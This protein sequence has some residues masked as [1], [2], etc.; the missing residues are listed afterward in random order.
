M[1]FAADGRLAT[2]SFDGK[3]R[4]YGADLAGNVHPSIKVD[5]PGGIRPW[6]IAFSPPPGMSIAVGYNRD[7]PA[8]DLLDGR[9]LNSLPAPDVSMDQRHALV[10]IVWSR[11]GATLFAGGDSSVYAWHELGAGYIWREL[12]AGPGKRIATVRGPVGGLVTLPD[13]DLL[14]AGAT[15]LIRMDPDGS[16]RWTREAPLVNFG[17]QFS[18]L[19]VSADGSQVEF[20]YQYDGKSRTRFDVSKRTLLNEPSEDSTLSP[21]K[22]TGLH[23]KGWETGNSPIFNGKPLEM[24]AYEDS[25]TVAINPTGRGLVLG[26]DWYLRAY[27]AQGTPL[28]KDAGRVEAVNITDDGRLVVAAYGDG[29]I[30]WHRMTDGAE[31]L[32]FMPLADRT[33]W[34]AWTPEGF[35][36]ATAGAEGAVVK[37]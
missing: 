30:R 13:G 6:G 10:Q 25:A 22:Q 34:V 37:T 23:V 16:T 15:Q 8:I 12:G 4:L 9:N 14:V 21:P 18:S 20:G 7:P 3:L 36:A 33:N 24:K 35:Y 31:L 29:T 1:D 26:T 11:D 19:A 28:W 32:A 27:D 17:G 5:A 2:T